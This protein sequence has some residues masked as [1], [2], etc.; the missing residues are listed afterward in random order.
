MIQVETGAG[1]IRHPTF[2]LENIFTS[3]GTLTVVGG[4]DALAT[5]AFSGA[6]FDF[7]QADSNSGSLTISL[8]TAATADTLCIAAH[9][10]GTR[11]AEISILKDIGAGFVTVGSFTP[12]DD[13]PIM[14]AFPEDEAAEWRVNF[15]AGTAPAP[16]RVG[17]L[18]LG[19]RLTLQRGLEGGYVPTNWGQRVEVLGG[20]TLSGQFLGQRVIRRSGQTRISP[21]VM[22]SAWW[23]VNGDPLRAHYDEGLPFFYA[24][25]PSLFPNDLAYCWRA[26]S[27]EEMRPAYQLGGFIS[28]GFEVNFYA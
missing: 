7:W 23:V 25:S 19:R 27:A 21:V 9:N 6:T 26:P 8:D 2:L 4:G 3:P 11:K 15:L 20:E 17:V 12:T 10:A 14:I 13:S 1:P 24:G 28:V 16:V 5:R 18:M 22:D